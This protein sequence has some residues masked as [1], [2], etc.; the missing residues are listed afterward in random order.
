MRADGQQRRKERPLCVVKLEHSTK[1]L[2]EERLVVHAPIGASIAPLKP[3]I[4]NQLVEARLLHELVLQHEA[5]RRRLNVRR[6]IP[7]VAKD[8][9]K[10]SAR[11]P[12]DLLA[13]L[14]L[15]GQELRIVPAQNPVLATV[16][17]PLMRD[18]A[19]EKDVTLSERVQLGHRGRALD[20]LRSGHGREVRAGGCFDHDEKNVGSSGERPGPSLATK[21]TPED[22]PQVG[23]ER[24]R[25]R[26]QRGGKDRQVGV[27]RVPLA[28]LIVPRGHRNEHLR[29]HASGQRYPP[30]SPPELAWS[31]GP[32]PGRDRQGGDQGKQDRMPCVPNR[33]AHER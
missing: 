32:H 17:L 5:E 31:A 22:V 23:A 8:L 11:G 7:F 6:R 3:G 27:N 33:A 25:P 18:D 2:L 14:G 28:P 10:A 1:R 15:V 26:P 19:R 20:T 16:G 9:G 24:D 13:H 30:A 4:A 21:V 12:V 29:E